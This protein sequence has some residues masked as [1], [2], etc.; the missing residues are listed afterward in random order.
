MS[1]IRH[2][3]IRKYPVARRRSTCNVERRDQPM[4]CRQLCGS[5]KGR[6]MLSTKPSLSLIIRAL[7]AFVKQGTRD[8]C[9][10]CVFDNATVGMVTYAFQS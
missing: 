10:Q 8:E 2:R 1:A 7:S 5:F 4:R 6:H 9:R 3:C